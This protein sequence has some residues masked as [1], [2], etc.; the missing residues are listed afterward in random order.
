MDFISAEL[1]QNST[2]EKSICKT[3]NGE[4]GIAR[5][6]LSG[7]GQ[8]AFLYFGF[9]HCLRQQSL[10]KAAAR[11]GT[12][13]KVTLANSSPILTLTHS[14]KSNRVRI[15]V[16]SPGIALPPPGAGKAQTLFE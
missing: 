7:D 6:T 1:G 3:A 11:L 16:I 13:R 2:T 8:R 4:F 10:K 12:A 5:E 14:D 15:G 9:F